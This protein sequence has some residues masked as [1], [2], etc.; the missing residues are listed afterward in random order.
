[1]SVTISGGGGVKSVQRGVYSA[2][3]G[4]GNAII[5]P[6]KLDKSVVIIS[7]LSNLSSGTIADFQIKAELISET[8]LNL[9]RTSNGGDMEVAWQVIEY[10]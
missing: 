10:A 6:V 5:A 1:M 9:S 3:L 8:M 7:G 2:Q 4:G